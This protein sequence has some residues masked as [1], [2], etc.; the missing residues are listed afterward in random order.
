MH[1]MFLLS[2]AKDSDVVK[3]T[4]TNDI[5]SLEICEMCSAK[6]NGVPSKP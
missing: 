6:V 5:M 4:N 3:V 1:V 2:S